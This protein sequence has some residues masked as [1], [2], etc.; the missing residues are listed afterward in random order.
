MA[1]KSRKNGHDDT[2][3]E[4][5]KTKGT[6]EHESGLTPKRAKNAVRVAKIVIPA[7]GPALIPLAVRAASGV[8][9]AYDRYQARKMGIPVDQ[10]AEYSGH[11]GALLARI[12]GAAEGLAELR[13][14]PQATDDDL[15]FTQHAQGTLE[16]LTASVRAAEHMPSARRKAAHKA[17]SS[18]LDGVESELLRRL[19]VA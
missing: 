13:H 8:R 2:L 6:E 10:L 17:V 7:V 19:G 11:G 18:E 3:A 14:A 9:D 12:S 15:S 5:S 16:Q 1:R 4:S